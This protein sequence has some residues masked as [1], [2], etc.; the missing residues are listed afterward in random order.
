METKLQPHHVLNWVTDM[1]RAVKFYTETLGLPLI[2]Y[3]DHFSKV[4]GDKYWISLHVE[5]EGSAE[6]RSNSECTMINLKPEIDGKPEDVDKAYEELKKRGVKFYRPPYEA[7]SSV[8]V[9]EFYDSEGNKLSLSS[10]D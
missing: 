4:G 5:K 9:A 2:Y 1:K 6:K 10:A 7:S 3:S 8:R